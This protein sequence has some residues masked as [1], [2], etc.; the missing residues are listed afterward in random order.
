MT[1]CSASEK[2][3]GVRVEASGAAGCQ[4]TLPLPLTLCVV[5]LTSN[6]EVDHRLAA[7]GSLYSL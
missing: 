4:I 1:P 3:A 6:S 2:R 7:L 5:L